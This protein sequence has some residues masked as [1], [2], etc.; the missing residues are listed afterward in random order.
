MSTPGTAPPGGDT[1]RASELLAATWIEFSISLV[2]VGLRFYTR[3]KITRN[4]WYDDWVILFTM[5]LTVVF[6]SL[7]TAYAYAGGARHVYYLDPYPSQKSHVL[8][9]NWVSQVFC[10]SGFGSGKISVAFHDDACLLRPGIFFDGT[11]LAAKSALDTWSGNEVNVIIW[12]ACCPTLRPLFLL[13]VKKVK[14]RLPSIGAGSYDRKQRVGYTRHSSHEQLRPEPAHCN[15]PSNRLVGDVH[16]L[17]ELDLLPPGRIRKTID[18]DVKQ[19]V[20]ALD[21]DRLAQGQSASA[22]YAQNIV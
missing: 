1:S 17:D 9:L 21:E 12:A 13:C 19:E 11:V 3:I 4:L 22:F 15:R 16:A 8:E 10:I 5:V 20:V 14:K 18:L 7:F 6:S 2:F